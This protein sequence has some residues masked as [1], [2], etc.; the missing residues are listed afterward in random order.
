MACRGTLARSAVGQSLPSLLLL[1]ALAT[2]L[3]VP[4]QAQTTAV[5]T[6]V[7]IG[8]P[9]EGMLQAGDGNFYSPSQPFFVAC[10]DD[11][12]Q[13]CAYIYK[14]TPKGVASIFYTFQR[15]PASGGAGILTINKDGLW[16]VALFVGEDGNL[17][18][19][20]RYDGPL[21][22]GTIFRIA[23]ADG[24]LTV[25][26]SFKA[27]DPGYIPLALIQGADGDFYFTNGIGIYRLTS[28]GTVS[29]VYEYPV[30]G[31]GGGSADS[32]VQGSDG[33]LYITQSVQP[34]KNP[35]DP[36]TGAILRLTLS[37]QP[38]ILHAF[39]SDGSEGDGPGGPLVQGSDGGFYGVTR[40][41][42][43]A[44]KPGMAF[45][46]DAGHGFMVLQKFNGTDEGNRPNPGLIVGSDTNLYGTTL[47]GGDT[48][49]DNLQ[50]RRMRHAVPVD[51]LGNP[52][53]AS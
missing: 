17:Y 34:N 12:T 13:L 2:A 40:F 10:G 36:N 18:G 44:Q 35:A 51:A 28:D 9:G 4:L 26:K 7:A 33:D 3:T 29:A 15:L 39:A 32:I 22:A 31:T 46:V 27:G 1:V 8:G 38:T 42:G 45:R 52:H 6:T 49:S 48:T 19:A 23:L 25:L 20:C 5:T 37:G 11:P 24:T 53:H 14:M 41:S 50:A 16:P 43:N 30:D 21:G 47:I